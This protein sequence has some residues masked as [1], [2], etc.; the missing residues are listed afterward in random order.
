MSVGVF[1]G[2][3]ILLW[4]S[5]VKILSGEL[6]QAKL[7]GPGISFVSGL[8][9]MLLIIYTGPL[10]EIRRSIMDLGASSAAFIAYVHRVLQVSHTFSLYYLRASVTLED[11]NKSCQL[12]NNSMRDTIEMLKETGEKPA[13]SSNKQP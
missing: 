6:D 7:W 9:S 4:A 10:K 3:C 5:S 11:V 1:V 2:G 8:G 13:D 12:I